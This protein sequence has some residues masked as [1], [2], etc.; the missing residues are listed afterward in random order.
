LISQFRVA[1][2]G[3]AARDSREREEVDFVKI[4]MEERVVPIEGFT[5]GH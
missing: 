5:K 3:G 2:R 4:E 1:C